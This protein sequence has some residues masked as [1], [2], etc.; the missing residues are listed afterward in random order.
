MKK[1]FKILPL[2][3]LLSVSLLTGCT[4]QEEKYH[5]EDGT[6]KGM[7]QKHEKDESGVGAGYATCT[8]V[9]SDEKLESCVFVL[10]ELD[11]T[12]KDEEYGKYDENG[13]EY[14]KDSYLKAQKAIQAA[15]RYAKTLIENQ[16]LTDDDV[17]SG[18]TI[19]L[20]ECIEAVDDALKDAK[21]IE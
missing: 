11:G 7:S 21:V 9:V 1:I 3:G 18:A 4:N 12:V 17:I 14:S 5:Y 13:V 20:S 10:Y 2:L 8:I 15:V 19:T 16:K 6:Y